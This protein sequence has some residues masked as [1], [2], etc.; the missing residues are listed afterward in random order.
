[1]PAAPDQDRPAGLRQDRPAGLRQGDAKDRVTA[2]IQALFRLEGSRRLHQQL[3]SAAGVSMS[4]QGYRLLGRIVE[5]GPTSPGQL[6]SMLELDPAVVARLLRQL[7][8]AGWVSRHRSSEDG[9]MTVVEVTAEGVET[10]ERM[11]EV[12]WRHM[13]RALSGWSEDDVA[14]LSVLLGRLVDDVQRDPYPSL[15]TTP[16]VTR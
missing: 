8:D 11:R 14:Q 6:A 12:I 1:M 7:E 15:A 13:R 2:A 16:A 10:F 9:R 4:Q 5:G 3:A